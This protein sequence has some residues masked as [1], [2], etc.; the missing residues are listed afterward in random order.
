M[1]KELIKVRKNYDENDNLVSTAKYE[2]DKRGELIKST[3][4]NQDSS[5]K[6]NECILEY[7]E[8]DRIISQIWIIDGSFFS[9]TV[10]EY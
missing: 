10:N 2:Y 3:I 6:V 8:S 1:K 7:D 9:K 4:K 5:I